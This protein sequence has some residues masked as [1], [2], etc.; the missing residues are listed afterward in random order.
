MN[1]ENYGIG[2]IDSTTDVTGVLV[3]LAVK[4][5]HRRENPVPYYRSKDLKFKTQKIWRR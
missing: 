2:F 3:F 5:G 4:Y 1:F